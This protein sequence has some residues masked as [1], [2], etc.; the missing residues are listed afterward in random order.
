M[1]SGM[2]PYETPMFRLLYLNIEKGFGTSGQDGDL[3]Y[4]DGG[5]AWDE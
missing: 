5:S 4:E 1:N 3:K 2:N